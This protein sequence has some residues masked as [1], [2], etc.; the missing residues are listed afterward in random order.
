[1]RGHTRRGGAAADVA[2]QHLDRALLDHARAGDQ[3]QQARLADA[4]R[5]D[6]PDHAAG[7]HVEV[8][9]RRALTVRPRLTVA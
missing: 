4:V 5:P 9:R 3:R 7:G 1:M 8:D 2:A 6:Q